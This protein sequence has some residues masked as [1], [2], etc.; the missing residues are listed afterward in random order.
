LEEALDTSLLEDD[1][2]AMQEPAHARVSRLA[3]VD[4]E[5]LENAPT[6]KDQGAHNWVLML[7][8]GVTAKRDS[9]NP[10][11]NPATTVLGPEILP[12]SSWR[13]DLIASKATNPAPH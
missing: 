9:V 1:L 8:K 10:A 13:I 7:S 5:L 6:R 3:V 11:P 12:F 4:P 2:A